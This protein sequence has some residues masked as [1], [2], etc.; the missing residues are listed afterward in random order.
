M[1]M[2]TKTLL[3]G[4][5]S[6][7]LG[8]MATTTYAADLSPAEFVNQASALGM[9]E[10]ETAKMAK[11]KGSSPDVNTF[12]QKMI[13]DHT[14]SNKQLS[15]IAKQKKLEVSTEADLMDKAKAMIL[16]VRQ[17]ESFDVAY[18]NNQ[19][20]SHEKTIEL[21]RQEAESGQ[22]SELKSFAKSTL[23]TLEHHLKMAKALLEQQ[24]KQ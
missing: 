16:K 22:D 5:L 23:P 13:D 12:A 10:I 9:A 2:P 18:A 17:G 3:A 1:K 15:E 24:E 21:Y 20:E 7:L 8:A 4:S 19:V 11:E 6:L 14:A